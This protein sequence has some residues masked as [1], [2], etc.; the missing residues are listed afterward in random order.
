MLLL[1]FGQILP[2][3]FNVIHALEMLWKRGQSRPE[4][5]YFLFYCKN[6]FV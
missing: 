6:D 3:I 1:L 5:T 4:D 2:A